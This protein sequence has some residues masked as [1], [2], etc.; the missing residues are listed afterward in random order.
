MAFVF[1]PSS[2]L[3]LAALALAGAAQAADP[4]AAPRNAAA[5]LEAPG[6]D[7]AAWVRDLHSPTFKTRDDATTSLMRLSTTRLG[8]VV[9]ALQ[10]ETDDEA[11]ARLLRAAVHL[12]LRAQ[13]PLEGEVGMLG[14]A[15]AIESVRLPGHADYSGAVAVTEVQ[16]GFPAEEYL[17]PGDRLVALNGEAFPEDLEVGAFRDRVNTTP[18]GSLLRFSVV[19][20]GRMLNISVPL[21][22]LPLNVPLVNFVDNRRAAAQSFIQ[23]HGP[24]TAVAPLVLPDPVP[25]DV[26]FQVIPADHFPGGDWVAPPDIITR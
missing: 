13:T 9:N 8:E 2:L 3:T 19:R 4:S 1:R 15:L 16:P 17:R 24:R 25:A 14:I 20:N 23:N 10:K 6:S 21:A 18:P 11:S 26:Q 7:I 22:G 5:N 12:Y